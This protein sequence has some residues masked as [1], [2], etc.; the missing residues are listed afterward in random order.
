M[1]PSPW[2]SPCHNG[3][4][5][6]A[7][8]MPPSDSIA[9]CSHSSTAGIAAATVLS[10]PPL[11]GGGQL[12]ALAQVAVVYYGV[13]IVL[14]C[15][16][17]WLVRP[18]SIQVAP[19]REGQAWQEARNSLGAVSSPC[20]AS[21]II[22]CGQPTHTTPIA[23]PLTPLYHAE[24]TTRRYQVAT[25]MCVW[26]RSDPGES[27]RAHGRGAAACG[28]VWQ[29]VHCLALEHHRGPSVTDRVR[30]SVAA[31]VAML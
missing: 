28:W 27:D 21:R 12:V 16:V 19:R 1:A 17:P 11:Y 6:A 26:R 22:V 7:A 24:C 15:V 3:S 13:A 20:I 8:V 23:A 30:L 18:P 10:F 9:G 4:A 29:D 2:L 25:I 5:A 14:H 31:C